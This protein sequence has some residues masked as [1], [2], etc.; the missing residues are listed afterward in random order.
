LA[1]TVL[2]VAVKLFADSKSFAGLAAGTVGMALACGAP[3]MALRLVSFAGGEL[4]AAAQTAGG[5]HVLS[6]STSVAA[7]Q[8]SRQAGG[9]LTLANMVSRSAMTRPI[10]SSRNVFPTQ[11]SAPPVPAGLTSPDPDG[12]QR[13]LKSGSST[14]SPDAPQSAEPRGF[15]RASPPSQG[16][17][18][19]APARQSTPTEP[20]PR[21][22]PPAHTPGQSSPQPPKPQPAR[23]DPPK[24]GTPHV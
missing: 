9:R 15:V 2:A 21:A 10:S 22:R 13:A 7:R 1:A 16:G 18:A 20:G 11:V 14:G 8:I 4:A 23:I 17:A 6:R 12:G 24:G 19:P 5:G 3:M